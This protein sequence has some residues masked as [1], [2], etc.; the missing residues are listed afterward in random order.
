M[1][2][3]LRIEGVGTFFWGCIFPEPCPF[4]VR[5]ITII[6]ST[7]KY[8]KVISNTGGQSSLAKR[9]ELC[10]ASEVP[11]AIQVAQE[12]RP[13]FIQVR[14]LHQCTPHALQSEPALT[15]CLHLCLLQCDAN[16]VNIQDGQTLAPDYLQLHRDLGCTCFSTVPL[17]FG[18]QVIGTL[19]LVTN[20]L[21]DPG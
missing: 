19:L 17:Y 20:H 9:G 18:R 7:S 13:Q 4:L 10:Q 12:G 1:F 16:G 21:S 6:S 11:T 8:A 14:S 2:G 3:S 15:S 5:S